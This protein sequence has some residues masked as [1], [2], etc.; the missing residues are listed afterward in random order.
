MSQFSCKDFHILN[1]MAATIDGKIASHNR[2]SSLERN[3]MGMLC[4]EDFERMRHAVASCDV[5]FIGARSMESELGAFRVSELTANKA[6]PEWIVFTRSGNFSFQHK[7][8][9]QK[10]IPKSIFFVTSFDLSEEPI[11]K[12]GQKIEFC[13]E[14]NYYLGNISGL[15]KYLIHNNKKRFALLGGGQLNAAFWEQG[16]VH[17]LWLTLSP[18]LIGNIQ[19]PSLVSSS[20]LLSKKLECQKVTQS[21]DFV[22]INYKVS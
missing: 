19:S 8:W 1:V 17:E 7:F 21:G 6:E 9:G 12:V 22:F 10:H 3:L 5:V 18:I 13:G 16:L 14:I 20:H 11:L 15:I 4:S 2:Q